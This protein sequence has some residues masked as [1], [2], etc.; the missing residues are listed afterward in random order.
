MQSTSSPP[1]KIITFYSYKGGTGRSMA[2]ANIACLLAQ[3]LA[4]TSQRVLVMDWDLEAPGL[5]RFFAAKCEQP[6]Y[7]ATPGV[8]DYFDSLL[9]QLIQ[10][11]SLVGEISA[12]GGCEVLDKLIPLKDF[13]IPDVV[14]GVDFM[15]AGRFDTGYAKLIG[16][17]DWIEFFT[18]YE[19]LFHAFR[20]LVASRYGYC[21]IDSRTG[22]TDVSGICTTLLPEKLVGVFTP[23]RQ[24]LL[25]VLDV[26]GQAIDYRGRSDDFRPLSV[27]P[28]PSRVENAEQDLKKEWGKD[29]QDRFEGLFRKAHDTQDCD[30][31]AYFED[32]LLPHVPYYAYGENI[33]VLE[34]RKDAISLSAAYE[35]FFKRLMDSDF[36]WEKP[37]P[38]EEVQ[39]PAPS[40]AASRSV[41]VKY[42]AFLSYAQADAGAVEKLEARLRDYGVRSFFDK[43]DL[44]AGEE[45]QESL[46]NAMDSSKSIVVC[47]GSKGIGSSQT[48]DMQIG[49]ERRA[50]DPSKRII[51]VVLP[52]AGDLDSLRLPT[53]LAR[54][55]FVD[56][57][58]GLDDEQALSNLIWSITGER[59]KPRPRIFY[60]RR[61][62][63]IVGAAAMLLIGFIAYWG[64]YTGNIG[65]IPRDRVKVLLNP[66]SAEARVD[67]A[68]ALA[69]RSRWRE[70][71]AEYREAIRLDPYNSVLHL[72]LGQ[73]LRHAN[74]LDGAI[75]EYRVVV[76]TAPN[77]ASL[78]ADLAHLME[79]KGDLSGALEEY[80]AASKLEPSNKTYLDSIQNLSDEL[81]KNPVEFKPP[82]QELPTQRQQGRVSPE[83]ESARDTQGASKEKPY[84]VIAMTSNSREEIL[85]EVNRVKK[86]VGVGF[87]RIFPNIEIYA[88]EGG[89]Y[90]L[91]VSGKSLPYAQAN[92]MKKRAIAAGFSKETWLW[93]SSVQYFSAKKD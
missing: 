24:S 18:K 68:K 33:A 12:P 85:A 45:W 19:S 65:A 93:Q 86:S 46:S 81:K 66:N 70:A 21:L 14:L 61:R 79:Q 28:L 11:P 67:L 27:F 3:R 17:F 42:D 92:Q 55:Q 8:I 47:I 63:P 53:F 41:E 16:T 62:W 5:H 6:E 39:I 78:R 80:R 74:D 50:R 35:R 73:A 83:A 13:L 51:P 32:V 31:T 71:I 64:G 58:S 91:L 76:R 60:K 59:P 90:T 72:N 38:P 40:I 25:G 49:L 26:V 77:L 87:D 34:E 44:L 1:G 52:T 57:R 22:V 20:E 36:A 75:A 30:L 82:A 23:N 84:Y 89:P 15:R 9:A 88:P 69:Y 37:A 4:R 2:V 7:G 56:L 48:Q 10:S 43:R 29:Y 54:L